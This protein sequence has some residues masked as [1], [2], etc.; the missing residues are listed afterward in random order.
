M[1]GFNSRIP[2]VAGTSLFL[3]ASLFLTL[4]TDS[5]ERALLS[6]CVQIPV[7]RSLH[8]SYQHLCISFNQITINTY[9]HRDTR[10]SVLALM[11]IYS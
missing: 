2:M 4:A 9:S 10:E 7:T 3:R 1:R 8:P 11:V 5:R 6:L